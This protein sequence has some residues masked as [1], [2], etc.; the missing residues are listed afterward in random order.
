MTCCALLLL[1]LLLVFVVFRVLVSAPPWPSL[2]SRVTLDARLGGLQ[3]GAGF[4]HSYALICPAASLGARQL[5]AAQHL[6]RHDGDNR[7]RVGGGHEGGSADH[8]D[9]WQR[10][11][12]V[13]PPTQSRARTLRRA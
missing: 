12:P 13:Q 8:K 9:G 2:C 11:P 3:I 5:L 10:I 1:L 4:F 7:L 6:A